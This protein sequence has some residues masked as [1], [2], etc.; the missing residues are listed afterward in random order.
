MAEA[1]MSHIRRA[2]EQLLTSGQP[3]A[4]AVRT[5]VADSW[6]R[7]VQRG[8]DPV[9]AEPTAS[10]LTPTDFEEYRKAHRLTAIREL[11]QSLML[12]DIADS[13][14]VVAL[15]DREGRLLWIEGDSTARDRAAAINFVEG[16]LW[17]EDTVGTNAPGLALSLGRGVQILGPEHFASS[18]QDWNCAAAPVHDPLTGELLGVID[19]TGG[20]AAAAPFALAA[21]RSV[22]AAVERELRFAGR[23]TLP[24]GAVDLARAAVRPSTTTVVPETAGNRLTVLTAPSWTPA[25]GLTAPL[26]PRHAE[27]LLLL[28][29]HP[30]GLGTEQLAMLLSDDDLGAVT[31]RAEISRLRRDLGD[32]IAARPYRLTVDLQSDYGTVRELLARGALAEAITALGRG[33]LLAESTAPGVVELFEDLREDLRSRVVATG[34]PAV[35]TAW[36][37]SPHGRDD[38]EAWRALAQALPA[39]G[40]ERAVATGRL[41]LLDRRLGL[42]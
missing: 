34:D 11:V 41:R 28:S 20:S 10:I 26:S 25:T 1:A 13:G 24:N 36:T 23:P 5:M 19:V 39:G 2:Y 21:V 27:I 17:S 3:P 35:L 32:L 29:T 33:G 31:V 22:V 30:E 4:E 16:S 42:G 8:I 18:V 40:A 7:S 15:A 9:D 6:L 37:S 12:D 38:T 14:V